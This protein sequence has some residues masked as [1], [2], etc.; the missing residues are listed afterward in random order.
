MTCCLTGVCNDI[1][2]CCHSQ[3]PSDQAIISINK[4]RSCTDKLIFV[5]YALSWAAII[6]ILIYC[7][8]NGANTMKI[9]NGADMQG[10]IC[11]DA[12]NAITSTLPYNIIPNPIYYNYTRCAASCTIT[13][14]NTVTETP[15]AILYDSSAIGYYCMPNIH[16][17][18][19]TAKNQSIVFADAYSESATIINKSIADL[20][21][22]WPMILASTGICIL[23]ALVF[24]FIARNLAGVLIWS[25]TL[26]IIGAGFLAAYFFYITSQQQTDGTRAKAYKYT[27]I[28]LAVLDGIFILIVF[29]MRKRIQIAIEVIKESAVALSDLL[30]ILSFPIIPFTMLCA[31]TV[32]F[33]Y[34]S[35]Y[36]FSASVG[37][38]DNAPPIS[39]VTHKSYGFNSTQIGQPN[40]NILITYTVTYQ[41]NNT[42]RYLAAYHV[43]HALWTVQLI[44]Y[45]SYTVIGGT[46]ADWYWTERDERGHKIRGSD[47]LSYF[48]VTSSLYRAM[49]YHIGTIAFAALIIAI[50]EFARGCVAYVERHTRGKNGQPNRLQR[51]V[52]CIVQSLLACAQWCADKVSSNAL[53]YTAI[54]GDSFCSAAAASFALLWRNLLRVAAINVISNIIVWIGILTV[55]AITIGI[56]ALAL[57]RL[58]MFAN[59]LTSA[60]VPLIIIAVLSYS[61]ANI[62]FSIFNTTI[63]TIFM[64]FLLDSEHNTQTGRTMLASESLQ[65]LV[66]KYADDSATEGAHLQA[67]GKHPSLN[68]GTT[69]KVHP[70]SHDTSN[71]D[72][73]IYANSS[74]TG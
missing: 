66:G 4:N 36:L 67:R 74:Y 69:G 61:I 54:T 35:L 43:F 3:T 6:Y 40:N 60:Y 45:F 11:G 58:S 41:W 38:R 64:C 12:N 31:Y 32:W 21:I 20:Y 22:A 46:V 17:M 50:I 49:R 26:T 10:N 25:S 59:H 51:A 63:D 37:V 7:N 15:M 53:I 52:F 16:S 24:T 5:L 34:V 8:N 57:T 33:I 18:F 72:P 55:T 19:I 39:E 70:M 44:L 23:I 30:A 47:G 48:A 56:S 62:F 68:H 2:G 13:S 1:C 73:P 9:L 27:G 14:D 28:T 71:G 29:A 42:M 65:A